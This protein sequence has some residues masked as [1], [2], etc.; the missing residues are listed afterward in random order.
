MGDFKAAHPLVALVYFLSVLGVTMFV[1]HPTLLLLA[2]LGAF[3]FAVACGGIA[4]PAKTLLLY[5]LLLLA[6][7]CSNP[8]FS[9]RGVTPLFFINGHAVTAEAVLYGVNLGLLLA[10]TLAWFTCVNLVLTQDKWLYLFGKLS[11]KFG[12]LLSGALRWL[13]RLRR[14][15]NEIRQAQR[16]LGL[17]AADT[18]LNRLRGSLRVYSALITWG[19]ENAL[20]AAASMQARGY[21]LPGRSQYAPLRFTPA[22]ACLLLQILLLDAPVL[23]G[24]ARGQFLFAFYP[25]LQAPPLQPLGVLAFAA[26]GVLCF[27]PWL[28]Q[29]KEVALWKYYGSKT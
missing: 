11:P 27:L 9:Q 23:W 7:G 2:L 13:P 21:G 26:F 24:L 6:T 5:A 8:L 28:Y 29:I 25:A 17:Y 15:A 4:K 14:Q 1:P 3:C 12:A 22:D 19:L 20:H 10:A 16:T 18:W